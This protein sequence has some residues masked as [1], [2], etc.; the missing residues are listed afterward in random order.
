MCKH[1]LTKSWLVLVWF[2]RTADSLE[3]FNGST[4]VPSLLAALLNGALKLHKRDERLDEGLGAQGEP[5]DYADAFSE[6]GRRS[7]QTMQEVV[8]YQKDSKLMLEA[9]L[10]THEGVYIYNWSV[11]GGMKIA[12]GRLAVVVKYGSLINWH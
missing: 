8:G 1:I 3:Q 4:F 10:Q 7:R 9:A 12:V 6:V 2:A 11:V 5:L